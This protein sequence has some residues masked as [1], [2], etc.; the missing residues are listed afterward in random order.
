MPEVFFGLDNIERR[1]EILA[2]PS[3]GTHQRLTVFLGIYN[4][5]P[6]ID[7]LLESLKVQKW[8]PSVHLLV[9]DNFSTDDSLER[10]R[11]SLLRVDCKVT[12]VRNSVNLGA[13]GSLY[14]NADLI[15]TEW[16][17]FLHQDDQYLPNF[18]TSCLREISGQP[19]KD[20]ATISFDY[21]TVQGKKKAVH[22]ANP[23][24]F[25][26]GR[27]GHRAFLE[28]LA[29]HSIPWPCTVFKARY[30]LESPVPFHSSAFLDTEI[31]LKESG[32]GRHVYVSET[33]MNYRVHDESG[34]HALA[35]GEQEFLRTSSILRVVA[36]AD[37][38]DL[39]RSIPPTNQA[40]WLLEVSSAAEAYVVSPDLKK[41]LRISIAEFVVLALNYKNLDCNQILADFLEGIGASRPSRL[42][43]DLSELAQTDSSQIKDQIHAE[44][45]EEKRTFFS[46]ADLIGQ[47]VSRVP[48]FLV[49]LAFR[50]IP[51]RFIP[52]PWDSYKK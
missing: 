12:L 46:W 24:W 39:V 31:A 22:S 33:V 44:Q 8:N 21:L 9:V 3:L 43:R 36:S 40:N 28:N 13:L 6:F 37:F 32:R 42:I 11:D 4:S 20:I 10:L 38:A 48:R 52:R 23:T 41:L 5:V 25:A 19:H 18:L 30:L 50:L 45:Q 35:S 47:L 34:S 49:V 16:L 7:D 17:T 2:D 51:K 27:P 26:S 1:I 29:N 14:R 15:N